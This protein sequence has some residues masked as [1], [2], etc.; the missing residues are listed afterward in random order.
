MD[1][2]FWIPL[3]L[4]VFV[5]SITP[6]PNN[7]MLTAAGANFGYRRCLPHM[8][9]ISIGTAIM[10]LLVG[11]GLG[12]VFERVPAAY[13]ALRFIG[14]GYLVYLAWRLARSSG[15]AD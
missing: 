8:L 9:G 2:L 15:P 6:G 14:A 13:A 7:V 10:V 11:A 12:A 4:F 3:A 5:N 1:S